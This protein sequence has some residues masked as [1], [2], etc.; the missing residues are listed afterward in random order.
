[1]GSHIVVQQHNSCTQLSYLIIF[2]ICV[3]PHESVDISSSIY[4]NAFGHPLDQYWSRNIK[5][6]HQRHFSSQFF[7][8]RFRFTWQ[9]ASMSV[10]PAFT[11]Q[12][13]SDNNT[14]I[15]WCNYVVEK[16]VPFLSKA[17]EILFASSDM[18]STLLAVSECVF[19][20]FQSFFCNN[21]L[22]VPYATFSQY[23][24]SDNLTFRSYWWSRNIR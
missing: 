2:Y 17:S 22:D 19:L 6:E 14:A 18:C 21:F 7:L 4:C 23:T 20:I 15:Y 11:G 10:M 12:P 24:I 13:V 16:H 8:P 5:K 1:M 3:Q 9:I